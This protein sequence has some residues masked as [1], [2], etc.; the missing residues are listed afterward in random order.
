[1][2]IFAV[3]DIHIDYKENFE[4]LIGLS[5]SD[6]LNDVLILAGDV[7]HNSEN[8]VKAFYEL[9][10]RF[11]K[12]IFVP[13]N[14][15]IWVR[16]S[17]IMNSLQKFDLV[18]SLAKD[19]DIMIS[20]LICSD[21]TIIPLFGWYDYTFGRI[22]EQLYYSWADFKCCTWPKGY[23]DKKVTEYFIH[24]NQKSISSI[25]NS[26]VISFSHFMPRIDI[27]PSYIPQDKRLIYPV[28]GSNLL[29][30]QIR[31]IDS[32]IHFYG[33]SHVN[34]QIKADKT[35]Y[36]NNA[37]GYPHENRIAAKKLLCIYE[38]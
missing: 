37:F 31:K 32:I 5:K 23:D 24:M 33:H 4:W 20:P 34:M 13:G 36:I 30:E 10:K 25:T 17:S 9:R 29:E 18:L 38:K 6:Y 14:H 1:M 26:K 35:L 11:L 28:L 16:D 22:D 2:R 7:S 8:M 21:V 27:M 3:S 19:L 12:V 15:D